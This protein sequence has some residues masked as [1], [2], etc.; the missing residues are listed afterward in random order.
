[1]KRTAILVITA[2]TLGVL[3]VADGDERARE[4]KAKQARVD[5][6]APPCQGFCLASIDLPVYVPPN[7]GAPPARIAAGSRGV[8]PQTRN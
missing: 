8:H 4:P 2:L 5:H 3:G 1:M 6:P 7:R